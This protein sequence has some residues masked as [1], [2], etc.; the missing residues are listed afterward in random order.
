MVGGK[1]AHSMLSGV[2]RMPMLSKHHLSGVRADASEMM[3]SGHSGGA[4]GKM[5]SRLHKYV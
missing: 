5:A 4:R 3:A 1:M 2:R